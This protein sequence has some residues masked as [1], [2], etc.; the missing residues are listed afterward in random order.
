M[1]VAP[2]ARELLPDGVTCWTAES[3]GEYSYV[4]VTAPWYRLTSI[5][6]HPPGDD[7]S[8]SAVASL[9]DKIGALSAE[10]R[11]SVFRICRIAKQGYFRLRHRS[12]F[13]STFKLTV[14]VD[15]YMSAAEPGPGDCEPVHGHGKAQDIRSPVGS[16]H[17]PVTENQR[18]VSVNGRWSF[19]ARSIS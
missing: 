12:V 7:E 14:D 16:A 11:S 15:S 2:S 3:L 6:M 18:P 19:L 9:I 8:M 10:A 13:E 1:D 17:S 4:D 5:I